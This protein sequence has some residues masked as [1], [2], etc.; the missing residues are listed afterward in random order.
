M[1]LN[2]LLFVPLGF[3]L[4]GL[5]RN[6]RLHRFHRLEEKICEICVICG[7]LLLLSLVLET[8]QLFLPA[9]APSVADVVANGLG[10]L[11]GVCLYRAWAMGVGRALR[12]YVTPLNLLL[13]LNVYAIL[14]ASLTIYLYRT[15]A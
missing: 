3:G 1:P 8:A 14:A 7:S 11:L 6:H 4:A 9:R 12:R 13:G 5:V 15:S 2:V 10:A